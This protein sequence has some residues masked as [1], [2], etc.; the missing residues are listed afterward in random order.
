MESERLQARMDLLYDDRLDGRIDAATYDKKASEIR[1]QQEQIR[2]KIRTAEAQ[3]LPSASEAVDLMT[4]TSKAADLY[5]AQPV[6]ERRKLLHL[7]LK[8]A[9][10]KG[11]ELRTLPRE[12]FQVLRLSNSG[13]DG[14]D[15]GFCRDGPNFDNWRRGGDSNPRYRFRPV[16]RFSK[17]LLSTTQPPLRGWKHAKNARA[18]GLCHYTIQARL[19]VRS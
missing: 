17:P 14:N 13:S 19:Q 7:V 5:V 3:M 18:G 2:Q 1:E 16:R 10:W 11:G 4:L 8:E 6:A 9:S 15:K 12:P